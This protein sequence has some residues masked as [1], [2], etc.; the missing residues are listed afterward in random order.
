MTRAR[1]AVLLAAALSLGAAAAPLRLSRAERFKA[2]IG[3]VF[4]EETVENMEHGEEGAYRFETFD[5]R[6]GYARIL[7]PF[8]GRDDFFLLPG[9]KGETLVVVEYACG[10]AC[11]QKASAY[12]FDAQGDPVH[13][14]F[15][16]LLALPAF[17]EL[18]RRLLTLCFDAAGDFDTE[19]AA[20]TADTQALPACPF[21]LSLSKTGGPGMLYEPV[22]EASGGSKLSVAMTTVQPKAALKWNGQAFVGTDAADAPAVFLNSDHMKTL[23]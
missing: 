22:N 20:R 7:G 6:A 8:D 3:A 16:D 5:A 12:R 17:E 11:T 21:V 10:E 13:L 18:H 15:K 9:R 2:M 19:P 23:F 14:R 4:T 1:P